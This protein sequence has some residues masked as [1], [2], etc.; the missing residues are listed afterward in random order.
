MAPRFFVPQPLAAGPAFELPPGPARH[1]QVL[2]LQPGDEITLFD[3]LGGEWR[4][5]IDHM[6]RSDVR[7]NLIEHLAASRELDFEVTLAVG[8]PAND[9]M[10]GLVEKATELGVAAIQPL[11]LPMDRAPARFGQAG[12]QFQQGAFAAAALA[13]HQVG[14]PRCQ[15]QVE[16]AQDRFG[17]R[18][19]L[20][21]QVAEFEHGRPGGAPS[22]V[23]RRQAGWGMLGGMLDRAVALS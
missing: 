17:G 7:V 15:A 13:R 1:V 9:R 14:P 10:D 18:G 3:G 4:G 6:G 22:M 8:M 20:V 19:R 21:A 16:A 5:C 23:D 2:R 11:A 12:D